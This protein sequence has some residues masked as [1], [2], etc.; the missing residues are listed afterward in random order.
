MSRLSLL[1]VL[2]ALVVAAYLRGI[3]GTDADPATD[4]TGARG[5][6]RCIGE[7]GEDLGPLDPPTDACAVA[8]DHPNDAVAAAA[9]KGIGPFE[10]GEF[11]FPNDLLLGDATARR[12]G[13]PALANL[14][15]MF[16]KQ[17]RDAPSSE[18]RLYARIG[19][20]TARVTAED[21]QG[22]ESVDAVT[23]PAL[24]CA[25]I[26]LPSSYANRLAEAHA[27]GGYDTTHVLM[28]LFWIRDLGCP[29]PIDDDFFQEIVAGTADLIDHDHTMTTDLEIEAAAFLAY[30]GERERIPDGFLEGVVRNQQPNGAWGGWMPDDAPNG[31]TSGLA[32]LYLHE[33]LFPGRD[34][35]PTVTRCMRH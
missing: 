25:H 12:F 13:V 6:S 32:L 22:L 5:P 17:L 3:L 18:F 10:R 9:C 1:A 15:P 11:T 21:L 31:H 4:E 20:L 28:A 35:M 30:L 24:H 34:A 2:F 26:P 27:R 23:M 19:D 7:H 16:E 29:S 8:E 14:W 33:L